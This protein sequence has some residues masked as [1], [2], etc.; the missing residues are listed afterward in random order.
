VEK[1]R[2]DIAN[3]LP[4]A[5]WLS[6]CDGILAVEI[7]RDVGSHHFD[8]SATFSVTVDERQAIKNLG[9]RVYQ[10]LSVVGP[11]AADAGPSRARRLR[12]FLT[13]RLRRSKPAASA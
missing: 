12:A 9:P 6:I 10:A 4:D 7:V 13:A 3:A 8:Q 11:Y 5:H 2:G 1:Y